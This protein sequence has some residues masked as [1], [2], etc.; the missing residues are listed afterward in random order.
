MFY[1]VNRA[2][3]DGKIILNNL[4]EMKTNGYHEHS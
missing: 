1:V 3:V 2:N 4:I